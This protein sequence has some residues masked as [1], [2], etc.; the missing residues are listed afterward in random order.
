MLISKKRKC[1]ENMKKISIVLLAL[2]V[3]LMATG[4]GKDVVETKTCNANISGIDQTFTFTATNDEINKIDMVFVY[5]NSMFG[6]ESF[7][8]IDDDTKETMKETMLKSLG[9]EGNKYDGFEINFDI[10]DQMT[11]KINVD[12]KKADKSILSKIGMN[13]TGNEDMS[14][15]RAVKDSTDEG[16][17]C[18]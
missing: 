11:V 15:K 5:D 14:L 13:F 18:K 9:L 10:Q 16:Y 8:D 7:A 12:L 1:G 2:F 4:C 17:T 6:I 3:T